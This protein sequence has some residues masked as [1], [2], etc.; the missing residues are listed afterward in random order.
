MTVVGGN[1]I[2]AGLVLL[3]PVIAAAGSWAPL[4]SSL[5]GRTMPTLRADAT[6]KILT[7]M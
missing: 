5:Q 6:N 7:N 1:R 3:L 2:A 4:S